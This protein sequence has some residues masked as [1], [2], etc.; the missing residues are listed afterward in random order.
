MSLLS[1]R[2]SAAI[3]HDGNDRPM[4]GSR[5]YEPKTSCFQVVL[6]AM[7][8]GMARAEV[9]AFELGI[10]RSTIFELSL[11]VG[12]APTVQWDCKS[13]T[14]EGKPSQGLQQGCSTRRRRPSARQISRPGRVA[15]PLGPRLRWCWK[16]DAADQNQAT[17]STSRASQGHDDD[18]DR[19]HSLPK[20]ASQGPPYAVAMTYCVIHRDALPH[21]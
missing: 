15:P 20:P 21:A 7:L 12:I 13:T 3:A 17:P 6:N 18:R 16:R 14:R 4:A 19:H 8:P 11:T 10:Y 9:F 5:G 1:S 2:S